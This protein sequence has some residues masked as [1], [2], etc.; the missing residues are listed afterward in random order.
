[1]GTST[2]QILV[3]NAHPYHQGIYGISHVLYLSENSRP[4]WI[5]KSLETAEREVIWIPTL[6]NMLEDALLMIAIYV[7]KDKEVI[8][9]WKD[10]T[11]E[12]NRNHMELYQINQKELQKM[13]EQAR[14]L[15]SSCKLAI[16]IFSDSSINH[17][18]SA[19]KFYNMDFEVCTSRY[20]K[21]YSVWSK[22]REER[23]SL[24]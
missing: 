9:L 14:E 17:Q 12:K 5:L 19:I 1:M 7:V 8:N 22:R 6:E 13:Y 15:T 24:I 21:H 4:A 16:T 18:L 10:Y 11:T 2:A 20:E 23:G 3:G